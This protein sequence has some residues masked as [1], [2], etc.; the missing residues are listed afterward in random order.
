[1]TESLAMRKEDIIA[2]LNQLDLGKFI[3]SY[4]FSEEEYYQAL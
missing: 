1:M 3:K 4:I 2:S